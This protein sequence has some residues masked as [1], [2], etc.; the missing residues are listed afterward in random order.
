MNSYR[1]APVTKDPGE[2]RSV[3]LRFYKVCANFWRPNEIYDATE[4]VRPTGRGNGYAFQCTQAG[5]SGGREPVWP[6]ALGA[7]V[8]D[9]SIV[10]TCTAAAGNGLNEITVA[11]AVPDDGLSVSSPL[12][13]EFSNVLVDYT[14][15]TLGQDYDVVFTVTINGKP[16]VATQTVKVRKQ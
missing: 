1:F 6:R 2:T 9:G 5:T 14:G 11:S 15:G 3:I 13:T 4:Y 16:R 7:T 8:V 10:W 12:V